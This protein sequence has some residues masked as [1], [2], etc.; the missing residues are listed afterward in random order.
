MAIYHIP[1][2]YSIQIPVNSLKRIII[3]YK[4]K[5]PVYLIDFPSCFYTAI[6]IKV[7]IIRNIKL[8]YYGSESIPCF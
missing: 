8:I 1:F 4:L 5:K 6:I 3:D 7:G 2:M